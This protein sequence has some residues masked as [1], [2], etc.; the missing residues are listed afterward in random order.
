MTEPDVYHEKRVRSWMTPIF[1]TKQYTIWSISE[2]NN[3]GRIGLGRGKARWRRLL[4]V[5]VE[6]LSRQPNIRFVFGI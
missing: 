3:T 2:L 4:N 1:C 5:Q 6:M